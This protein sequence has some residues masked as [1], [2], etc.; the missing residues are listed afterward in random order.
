MARVIKQRPCHQ[1]IAKDCQ[2]KFMQFNVTA[3]EKTEQ[4]K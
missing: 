4:Y 3:N 2:Y 1:Y